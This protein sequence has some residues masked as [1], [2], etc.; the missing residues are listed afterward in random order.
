MK[1]NGRCH[2]GDLA[3]TA[4]VDPQ[5]VFVCHCSDCQ[6]MSGSAFR[7]NVHGAAADFRLLQG[8][9]AFYERTAESG[10]TRVH[11]FC[12]RC[13]SQIYST[14]TGENA[15]AMSIRTGTLAERAALQPSRQIWCRS[16]HP[17]TQALAGVPQVE[18][19]A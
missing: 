10:R 11:A 5:R 18:R 4:E 2:C 16:A 8:E 1:V 19:D 15:G 9:P 3:F 7:V 14:G 13:G 17:W 12:R 6:A